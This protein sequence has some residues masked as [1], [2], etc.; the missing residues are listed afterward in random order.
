MDACG[1]RCAITRSRPQAYYYYAL[2]KGERTGTPKPYLLVLLNKVWK[3]PEPDPG[4]H[5]RKEANHR[6]SRR[7]LGAPAARLAT[8]KSSHHFALRKA[9]H[10]FHSKWFS[11]VRL[12]H[13]IEETLLTTPLCKP[14]SRSIL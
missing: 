12:P 5:L 7:V 1:N 9:P 6:P 8:E 3:V 14:C 10:L 11:V 13:P 4:A 2:E